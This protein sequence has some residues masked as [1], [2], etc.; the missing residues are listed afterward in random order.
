MVKK[1]NSNPD[2]VSKANDPF[3]PMGGGLFEH[4]LNQFLL[5]QQQQS[6]PFA[7]IAQQPVNMLNPPNQ[8]NQQMALMQQQQMVNVMNMKGFGMN[9]GDF[10]GNN[11][12]TNFGRPQQPAM[13][14]Q[15]GLGGNNI[16]M[17]NGWR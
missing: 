15:Y 3:G 2:K 8:L 10:G 6:D 17:G 16:Y 9:K 1:D 12:M 13:F 14:N 7:M 4:L 5:G 11:I